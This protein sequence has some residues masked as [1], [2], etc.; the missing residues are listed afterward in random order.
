MEE[1]TRVLAELAGELFPPDDVQ[2]LRRMA[3]AQPLDR[4]ALI[5]FD[6]NCPALVDTSGLDTMEG[7]ALRRS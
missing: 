6:W 3:Q 4:G 1:H 5:R 2:A 7:P